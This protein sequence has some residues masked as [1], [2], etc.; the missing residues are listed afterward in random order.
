M[1]VRN[2]LKV[3][4]RENRQHLYPSVTDCVTDRD[5]SRADIQLYFDAS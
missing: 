1:R 2:E 3:S 4:W 5:L